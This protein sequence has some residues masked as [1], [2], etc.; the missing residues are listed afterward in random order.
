MTTG[1]W[2]VR[3]LAYTYIV[4]INN[5]ESSTES[6]ELGIGTG[7]ATMALTCKTWQKCWVN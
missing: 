2:M 3:H 7:A 4:D 1:G 6:V 5:P